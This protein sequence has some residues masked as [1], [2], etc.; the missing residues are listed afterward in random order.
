MWKEIRIITIWQREYHIVIAPNESNNWTL[1]IF[2]YY[3]VFLID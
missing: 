3:K 2:I 1:Y